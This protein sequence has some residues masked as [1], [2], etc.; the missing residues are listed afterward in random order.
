MSLFAGV[1][2]TRPQAD[3]D[4]VYE[5]G[6]THTDPGPTG[7]LAVHVLLGQRVLGPAETQRS[8]G[9]TQFISVSHMKPEASSKILIV[10]HKYSQLR[11]LQQ[12]TILIYSSLFIIYRSPVANQITTVQQLSREF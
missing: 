5:V 6:I 3:I 9:D 7:L 8:D 4:F 2:G 11:E 1:R 12:R 10:S